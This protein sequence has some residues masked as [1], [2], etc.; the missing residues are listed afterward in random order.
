MSDPPAPRATLPRHNLLT[1]LFLDP[2]CI[3]QPGASQPCLCAHTWAFGL[4][5]WLRRLSNGN[6]ATP[7]RDANSRE[8]THIRPGSPAAPGA[9]ALFFSS[10]SFK[11]AA[12]ASVP[13]AAEPPADVETETARPSVLFSGRTPCPCD[14]VLAA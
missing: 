13:P 11:A 14:C 1:S 8:L 5:A 9:A 7:S 6:T 12:S 2:L 3:G 4:H 10:S